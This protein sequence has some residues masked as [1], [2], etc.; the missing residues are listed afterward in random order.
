MEMAMSRSFHQSRTQYNNR[1]HC[2]VS[3]RRSKSRPRYTYFVL[4][5]L[6]LSTYELGRQPFGLASPAAW[7]RKRSHSVR[8]L[9]L[10]RQSLSESTI[11][12]A[13]LIVFYLPMHTA[14]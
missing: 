11:Q 9:D 4:R 8:A 1:L 5:I 14:T 12:D 2:A 13:E 7:L 3:E 6:L 10:S